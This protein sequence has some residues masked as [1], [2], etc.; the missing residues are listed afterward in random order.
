MQLEG[1]KMPPHTQTLTLCSA[2]RSN[3]KRK[4]ILLT[5]S[6]QKNKIP[7]AI[8]SLHFGFLF[9]S[10]FVC[11]AQSASY[12]YQWKLVCDWA[13]GT[14]KEKEEK[15]PIMVY[16][17]WRSRGF[18]L[19]FT[20]SHSVMEYTWN[21]THLLHL[22]C[23]NTRNRHNWLG[24]LKSMIIYVYSMSQ[25]ILRK[26]KARADRKKMMTIKQIGKNMCAMYV[27]TVETS[28]FGSTLQCYLLFF[29]FR[30]H[31][32]INKQYFAGEKNVQRENPHVWKCRE[33][34]VIKRNIELK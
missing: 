10:F 5:R 28:N 31:H 24:V 4:R 32:R 34:N 14:Q 20:F 18:V 33:K 3:V 22:E 12:L 8:F 1:K 2:F 16:C 9:F 13:T 15:L 21:M 7:Q 25:K 26:Y 29:S 19:W 30:Y 17:I 6:T 27:N 23:W 11:D